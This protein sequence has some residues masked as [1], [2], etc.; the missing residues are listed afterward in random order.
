MTARR[1]AAVLLLLGCVLLRPPVTAETRSQTEEFSAIY[2]NIGTVGAVGA[3]PVT[4]RITRWTDDAE[5]E[6]LMTLLR[7][8]GTE[9]LVRELTGTKS[10]GSIGTPQELPYD[11]RY[12]RQYPLE[13]GGRR[14]VLMTDR[15]MGPAE[16]MSASAS[17]D[18]PLT[19]IEMN[20][21]G[22]G[23]GEGSISLAVRL[24]LLGDVLGIEDYGNQ[25]AKLND[26]KKIK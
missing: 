8:K 25:P 16:R 17:R 15:P 21:D 7:E 23:R 5:N 18:Y 2:A 12:A 6:K 20:L 10:T 11:L 13:K 1:S 24:R 14:I 3:A 22:A 4:I 19:W 26:I 9:A